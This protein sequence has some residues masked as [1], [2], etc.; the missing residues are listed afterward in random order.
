M[1]ELTIGVE[2]TE[3][4]EV[5]SLSARLITSFV[6]AIAGVLSLVPFFVYFT[7]H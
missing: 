6:I 4:R 7:E 3:S 5:A 1:R 2:R